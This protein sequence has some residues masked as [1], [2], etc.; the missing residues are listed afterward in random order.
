MYFICFSVIFILLQWFETDPTISPRYAYISYFFEC[1]RPGIGLAKIM[2]LLD[3]DVEVKSL[4][5]K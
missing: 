1:L 5:G 2:S 4:N 3:F